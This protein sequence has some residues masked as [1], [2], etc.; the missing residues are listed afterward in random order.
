MYNPGHSRQFLLGLDNMR[1]IDSTRLNLRP[2]T[3]ISIFNVWPRAPWRDCLWVDISMTLAVVLLD[4]L[5]VG[6][7]LELRMVPVHALEPIVQGWILASDHAEIAL[8]VLDVD[9]V[10]TDQ[11]AE[12]TDID[13]GHVVA[14]NIRTFVMVSNLLEFVQ[15]GKDG[16]E[17]LLIAL[18]VRRK[19]SLHR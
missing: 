16:G 11:G 12:D 6:R 7:V 13:L 3:L 15:S 17:V 9:C 1:L 14:E 18:L 8:E 10:E 5:E 19:S 4:M 2:V